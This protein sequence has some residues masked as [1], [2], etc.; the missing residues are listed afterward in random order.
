MASG[1]SVDGSDF[2]NFFE[3]VRQH[4][5]ADSGFKVGG[6]DIGNRYEAYNPA[7]CFPPSRSIGVINGSVDLTKLYCQK[8]HRAYYPSHSDYPVRSLGITDHYTHHFH[9]RYRQVPT[10]QNIHVKPPVMAGNRNNTLGWR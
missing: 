1:Y 8:G 4:K 2:D 3:L 6:V 7:V 9:S 5:G 10:T